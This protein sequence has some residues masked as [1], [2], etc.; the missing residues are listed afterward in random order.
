MAPSVF[1]LQKMLNCCSTT[2]E[3][4]KLMFNCNKSCFIK[5]GP[6]YKRSIDDLI[7]CNHALSWLD[8]ITYLG[9]HFNS[10]KSMLTAIS[11]VTRKFFSACN[12]IYSN[13]HDQ[14]ELLQLQLQESV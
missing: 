12:Y 6:S 11:E 8:S 14:A 2:S 13:S 4:L 7:L 3:Y 10:N 1:G 5:F 9:M